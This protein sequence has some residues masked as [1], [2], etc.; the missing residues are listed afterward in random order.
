MLWQEASRSEEMDPPRPNCAKHVY[1]A[2]REPEI[3]DILEC[4]FAIDGMRDICS[5]KAGVICWN[6]LDQTIVAEG[7]AMISLLE[8]AGRE[9]KGHKTSE[10]R[11]N[12][13]LFRKMEGLGSAYDVPDRPSESPFNMYDSLSDRAC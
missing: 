3:M 4:R 12:I 10:D 2:G 5:G 8:I 9:Q 11:W 7:I 6:S 13:D 1:S